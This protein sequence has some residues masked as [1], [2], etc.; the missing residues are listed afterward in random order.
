MPV[1]AEKFDD[2]LTDHA[3]Y[4]V[5]NTE[6]LYF[7]LFDR[8]FADCVRE[9]HMIFVDGVGLKRVLGVTGFKNVK[10]LHGPDL[11]HRMI[12]R[13]DGRRR[14]IIGGS[15]TS[16]EKLFQKYPLL[17]SN[18][19][20]SFWSGF[21]DVERLD[22]LFQMIADYSADEVFVCL[23]IRKQELVA[24]KI[25]KR[26]PEITVVGVGAAIDFES[27]HVV[28]SS[29]LAQRLGLEWFTRMF[30]EPRMIPRH[31]RALYGMIIFVIAAVICGN[32]LVSK[33][34]IQ[35]KEA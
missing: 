29:R 30:R 5:L 2:Y 24:S 28:R 31:I 27:G 10:R 18:Q 21:V 14:L 35:S 25:K 26:F 12:H 20:R 6:G 19:D 4:L 13:Y 23:G 7:L 22:N 1:L 32:T 3:F 17:A 15:P 33:F 9:S 8:T 11:F 34:G 16:H